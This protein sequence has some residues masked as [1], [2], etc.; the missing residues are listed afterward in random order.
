MKWLTF[1][2]CVAYD[3]RLAVRAIRSVWGIAHDVIVAWDANGV[4]WG[5]GTFEPPT[6]DAFCDEVAAAMPDAI[7]G[8]FVRD[9][10]RV[11]EGRFWQPGR[12]RLELQQ[13]ERRALSHLARPGGWIIRLDAD[14]EVINPVELADTLPEPR[15]GLGVTASYTSVYKVI[16]ETALIYDSVQRFHIG[17]CEP[18]SHIEA[19][20]RAQE[21]FHSPARI[22]HWTMARTEDELWL[23]LNAMAENSYGPQ[24]IFDAWRATTL[25]NYHQGKHPG[26]CYAPETPLRPVPL[27]M[28][29]RVGQ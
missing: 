22:L 27:A 20:G 10:M 26:T 17:Q 28:L 6:R 13:A 11:F 23:K 14:E 19:E 24:V 5:G 16:G 2:L 12:T 9:R 4:T 29:R 15:P 8:S 7:G 25:T 21:W 1:V 18:G 3:W